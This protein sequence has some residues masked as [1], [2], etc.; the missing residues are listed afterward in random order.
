M[1]VGS[2]D[3]GAGERTVNLGATDR[4]ADHPDMKRQVTRSWRWGAVG[5]ALVLAGCQAEPLQGPPA[6]HEAAQPHSDLFYAQETVRSETVTSADGRRSRTTTTT[7]GASVDFGGL[8]DAV[9]GT[10]G[11]GRDRSD[12]YLGRW[13]VEQPDGRECR[14]ELRPKDA[15]GDGIARTSGCTDRSLFFVGR[16]SLRGYEIVLSNATG[17]ALVRLRRTGPNRLEGG[18]IVIWR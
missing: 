7:T 13:S 11:A 5:C 9:T 1:R 17:S 10:S 4:S 18:G 15:F 12:A 14:L 16:W 8:L 6:A 3:G 2:A